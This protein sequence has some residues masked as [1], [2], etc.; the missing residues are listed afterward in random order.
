[1][2]LRPHPMEMFSP[3][4][5]EG[6]EY[7]TRQCKSIEAF[8]RHV[9]DVCNRFGYELTPERTLLQESQALA[10]VPF[11]SPSLRA[12]CLRFAHWLENAHSIETARAGLPGWPACR[13]TTSARPDMDRIAM[14][15]NNPCRW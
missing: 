13:P 11:L 8:D 3:A 6:N 12:A 4:A 7:V 10:D 9:K 5:M 14:K 15:G 2:P 1:M